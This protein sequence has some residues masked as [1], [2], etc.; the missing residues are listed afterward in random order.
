[1]SKPD[2]KAISHSGGDGIHTVGYTTESWTFAILEAVGPPLIIFALNIAHN[3]N[4]IPTASTIR[5]GPVA[6]SYDEVEN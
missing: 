4:T 6:V 5:Q 3:A 1:M 2:S